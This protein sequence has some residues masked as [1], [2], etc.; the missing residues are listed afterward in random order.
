MLS[1][2]LTVAIGSS[3]V[4]PGEL[5]DSY[6]NESH[7]VYLDFIADKYRLERGLP[8]CIPKGQ[9]HVNFEW[10][11][12]KVEG[13][14]L[15]L[16]PANVFRSPNRKPAM[17]FDTGTISHGLE[18]VFPPSDDQKKFLSELSWRMSKGGPVQIIK[19]P[20]KGPYV[21]LKV[22]GIELFKWSGKSPHA[23]GQ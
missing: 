23:P 6:F 13:R 1:F 19:L 14:E 10:G 8:L 16:T 22:D 3:Q 9:R 18:R 17:A 7:D 2:L 20:D 5:L 15:I 21:N 12:A 4:M 11:Y